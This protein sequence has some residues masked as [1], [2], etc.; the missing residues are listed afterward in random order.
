MNDILVEIKGVDFSYGSVPLLENVNF[1]IKNH[2]FIGIIGANGSGKTTLI[3]LVT[4]ELLPQKGIVV[5]ACSNSVGYLPQYAAIDKHFP[6]SV[7][8]VVET[9]LVTSRNIWRMWLTADE[10]RRV[11]A[12]IGQMEL[13]DVA[14]IPISQL[15]GGQLQR[16]MLARAIVSRPRLL[17]LDEP[18]TYLDTDSGQR[19]LRLLEELNEQCAIV[20]V[21]HDVTTIENY[22]NRV[23]RIHRT[24]EELP[25]GK[26]CAHNH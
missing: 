15:S 14:G 7:R 2:D 24:L 19:L 12:V 25:L 18:E 11:D 6:I 22:C 3:K 26:P 8:E 17:L 4:G 13:A 1:V 10:Q 21:S 23:A 16:T 20:I 9:G 5:N